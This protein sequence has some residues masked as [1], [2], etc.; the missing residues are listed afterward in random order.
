MQFNSGSHVRFIVLTFLAFFGLSSL[1]SPAFSQAVPATCDQDFL[2]VMEARAW[3]E[4]KREMEVA[5]RLILKPDSVLEYSCFN[6]RADQLQGANLFSKPGRPH[7]LKILVTAS[8][9]NYL[10]NF[11]HSYGGGTVS[12]GSGCGVMRYVW[13]KLKCVDFDQNMFISFSEIAGN[14][15]RTVPEECSEPSRA[16]KWNTAIAATNP[17]PES[18]PESGGIETVNLF[19]DRLNPNCSNALAIPTGIEVSYAG[20]PGSFEEH[21]CTAP[22][23][24][25]DGSS[26]VTSP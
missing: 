17:A 23:C 4:G 6:T 25:Y 24:S 8:L 10:D 22:G 5:Q 1:P 19:L 15:P 18:P 2:D 7:S 26:C 14:D 11:W 13:D 3:M 9:N 16:D 21:V 20:V 12:G